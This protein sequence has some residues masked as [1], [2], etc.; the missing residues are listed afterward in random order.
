MMTT[1]KNSFPLQPMINRKAA[2]SRLTQAFSGLAYG[3][4]VIIVVALSQ[5]SSYAGGRR[6]VPSDGLQI[7][8][9]NQ[10]DLDTQARIDADG[11]IVFPY[12]GRIKAAGLTEDQL[13]SK[14]KSALA[15]AAIVKD[16]QVIVST[17]SF[18]TQIA[19]TGGVRAPA[20]FSVDR[21]TTVTEALA[22]AGGLV[23]GATKVVIKRRTGK[24]YSVSTVNA[25]DLLS[26]KSTLYV[27]NGDEIFVKE[28]TVFFLYGYVGKPGRYPLL[29]STSVQEA[30]AAGGGVTEMGSDW[31]IEVKRRRENGELIEK[32]I[33]LDEFVHPNDIIIVNERIF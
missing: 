14:I 11:T 6:L 2:M 26:G 1:S 3:L 22:R 18:G 8:V 19:V 32:S 12:A 4:L 25:N 7:H 20:V 13:A 23:E 15:K 17:T 30:L 29:D 31:R 16:P 28:P 33:S 9:V 5:T 27:E 24:G 10:G 21:P